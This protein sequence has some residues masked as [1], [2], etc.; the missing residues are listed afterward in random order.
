[1]RGWVRS[2]AYCEA[3]ADARAVIEANMR[4]GT[5]ET[6]PICPDVRRMD[7][8]WLADHGIRR[9][10]VDLVVGG[11][12]CTGMTMA[13][14]QQ[15]FAHPDTAL[16]YDLLRV[17]DVVRSP[18][19]FLENS[20]HILQLGVPAV[21]EALSQLARRG[22]EVRYM[23]MGAEQVGAPQRRR[24]W[25][26]LAVHRDASRLQFGRAAPAHGRQFDW[27]ACSEPARTS[28]HGASERADPRRVQ[29]I[30]RLGLSV[31]PYAAPRSRTSSKASH[32]R[33]AP[34]RS[35]R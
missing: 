16:F 15:G 12:P 11:W 20:A 4:R 34:L 18:L 26:C 5:L 32:R 3:D 10:G 31:V 21:G 29:R 35:V 2:L 7:R 13:G 33:H 14:K 23:V 30:C 19:V 6:A 17:V 27:A 22:Y 25:Y 1:M 8:A 9:G 28:A 24:R